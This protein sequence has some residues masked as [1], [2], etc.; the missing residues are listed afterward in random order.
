[1]DFC[2]VGRSS[3][4]SVPVG[5][6]EEEMRSTAKKTPK[7]VLIQLRI[8]ISLYESIAAMRFPSAGKNAGGRGRFHFFD[9]DGHY[10]KY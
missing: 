10:E 8:S 9:E 1:M 2:A 5:T 4:E 6:G 7:D 3:D